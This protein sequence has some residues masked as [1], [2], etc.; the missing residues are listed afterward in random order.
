MPQ[1]LAHVAVVVRNY[2][3]AITFYTNVL[4]FRLLEDSHLGDGKRWVLVAPAGSTGSSILLAQAA[5]PEQATRIGN[6]TGGR[7]FLFLHTD[8]FWRDYR[9]LQSQNVE[10]ARAPKEE[11]YGTVAVFKDLYGNL[12][13]LIQWKKK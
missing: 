3:E 5:T 11:P 4:G 2:D 8:D 13:D 7:V 12:W 9:A 1:I 10:F 6:Q